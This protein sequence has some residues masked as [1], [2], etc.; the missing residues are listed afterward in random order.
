[1]LVSEA[2]RAA[3]ELSKLYYEMRSRWIIAV[4]E[5]REPHQQSEKKVW[6]FELSD[7]QVKM[8]R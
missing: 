6:S 7:D 4:S 8:K 3:W 1:M 2:V 5:S